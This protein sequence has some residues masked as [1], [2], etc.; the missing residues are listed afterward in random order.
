MTSDAY[1]YMFVGTVI[2]ERAQFT[3]ETPMHSELFDFEGNRSGEIISY[4]INSQ[5][6]VKVHLSKIE[7]NIFSL[8][9]VVEDNIRLQ[10]DI[11]GYLNGL[12]YDVEI[13]QG[14]DPF[15]N[16]TFFGLNVFE[17]NDFIKNRPKRFSDVML[18]FS[19]E[20]CEYL[21][22]ALSDLREAIRN[23]KDSGFFC[24]RS[25]ECLRQYFVY[26]NNLD[27]KNNRDRIKSWEI[28][29]KELDIDNNEIKSVIKPY[30][31]LARHGV[32]V[33]LSTTERQKI[34]DLTW[35]I[36]DNYVV[37]ASN[38]YKNLFRAVA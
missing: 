31:D 9:D 8:K 26:K 16:V 20:N 23:P 33:Y 27:N 7:D 38:G 29:G 15:N 21:R 1:T 36:I 11:S 5:I 34:F 17:V 22:L 28:L 19:K 24:Y 30:A 35:K 14:Y 3:I 2:P 32:R 4:I 37:Y 6:S 18:I 13:T 10:L 25:I 12:G